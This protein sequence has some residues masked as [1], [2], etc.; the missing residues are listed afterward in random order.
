VADQLELVAVNDVVEDANL[1]LMRAKDSFM[2]ARRLGEDV[3][4]AIIIKYLI[5]ERKNVKKKGLNDRAG[6]CKLLTVSLFGPL[7]SKHGV[8]S[9]NTCAE[10]V[11]YA[12]RYYLRVMLR[13]A[14][15]CGY[16]V[17]Y[18]DTDSIFVGVKGPS[19]R[20]C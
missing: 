18:G 15:W 19:E 9:S 7:G 20:V 1:V 4:T 12:A 8:V 3:M 16:E 13:A 2:C 6:A 5:S 10:I 17:I 11:R 14:E